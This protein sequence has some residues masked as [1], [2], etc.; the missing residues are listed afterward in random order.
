MLLNYHSVRCLSFSGQVLPPALAF[1]VEVRC[2]AHAHSSNPISFPIAVNVV[3]RS[4][5]SRTIV[6]DG[7]I[8]A[9]LP[10]ESHLEIMVVH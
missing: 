7:D 9:I 8:V 6:L 3:C 5:E 1:G 4:V 10:P 2:L